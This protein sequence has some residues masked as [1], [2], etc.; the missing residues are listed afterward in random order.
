LALCHLQYWAKQTWWADEEQAQGSSQATLFVQ[1][2]LYLRHSHSFMP[3]T[4]EQT[5][6][7]DGGF[8]LMLQFVYYYIEEAFCTFN[9]HL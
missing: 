9:Y 7:Q 4:E 1:K 3:K 8:F 5:N 6:K 2:T